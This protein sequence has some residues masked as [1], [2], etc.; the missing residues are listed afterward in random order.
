MSFR[1][2][3]KTRFDVHSCLFCALSK[4]EKTIG[5]TKAI[6]WCHD[7]LNS[8]KMVFIDWISLKKDK[9]W[10]LRPCFIP[11]VTCSVNCSSTLQLASGGIYTSLFATKNGKRFMCFV[12]SST[13]QQYILGLENANFWKQAS[14]CKFLK[15]ILL[16]SLW[17][18]WQWTKKMK[19]FKIHDNNTFIFFTTFWCQQIVLLVTK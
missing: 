9:I 6:Q 4:Y 11:E 1:G 7:T 10:K 18:P 2:W 16:S 17:K 15:T 19:L 8:H 5:W 13:Q 12:L 3:N 14:K